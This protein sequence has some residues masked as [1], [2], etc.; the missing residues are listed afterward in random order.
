MRSWRSNRTFSPPC[1]GCVPKLKRFYEREA[2]LASK[3]SSLP[4]TLDII[5]G[6]G[7]ELR[8]ERVSVFPMWTGRIPAAT[9]ASGDRI[10]S[11]VDDRVELIALTNDVTLH[12]RVSPPAGTMRDR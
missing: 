5:L 12:G 11:L 6:W 1:K 9:F 10:A 4:E 2:T 3:Y 8:C 7:A